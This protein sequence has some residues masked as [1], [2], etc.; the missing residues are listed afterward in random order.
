M[1]VR[2]GDRQVAA[3]E[4]GSLARLPAT[5]EFLKARILTGPW[6][7]VLLLAITTI[8]EGNQETPPSLLLESRGQEIA[9]GLRWLLVGT[10]VPGEAAFPGAFGSHPA[11]FQLSCREGRVFVE[12][13]EAGSKNGQPLAKGATAP[14]V[15][16]ET[17]A[18]GNIA[19][20]FQP[21][22]EFHQAFLEEGE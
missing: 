22:P 17:V 9:P 12:A 10:P 18:W 20:E 21:V 11:P 1:A 19:L 7:T 6:E 14:V 13:R 2:L 16:G 5:L 15:P 4:S 3:G 8:G